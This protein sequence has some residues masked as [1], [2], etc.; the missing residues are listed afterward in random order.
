MMPIYLELL[1]LLS[2]LDIIQNKYGT[3]KKSINLI[4]LY[5][6]YEE[7]RLAALDNVNLLSSSLP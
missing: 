3:L 6:R 5:S 1:D 7:G 4:I 2:L